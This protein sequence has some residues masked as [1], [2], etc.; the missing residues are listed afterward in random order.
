M[1]C[2]S[3]NGLGELTM[4]RF[5]EPWSRDSTTQH[6]VPQNYETDVANESFAR[7]ETEKELGKRG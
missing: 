7:A 3:Y 6:L 2:F 5:M 1:A 4:G